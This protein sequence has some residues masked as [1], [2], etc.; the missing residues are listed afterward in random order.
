MYDL[1][2]V[3]KRL[4]SRTVR[5]QVATTALD[6]FDFD[7]S[8]Y[9]TS[10]AYGAY[11]EFI[12]LL[13]RWAI[14]QR[15]DEQTVR[16]LYLLKTHVSGC[17]TAWDYA[18]EQGFITGEDL[19]DIITCQGPVIARRDTHRCDP[20]DAQSMFTLTPDPWEDA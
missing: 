4:A 8:V 3:M 13:I 1:Q 14:G 18:L 9:W 12:D 20:I 15:T 2:H 19:E 7:C 16:M 11:D 10:E 17:V 6:M 5:R